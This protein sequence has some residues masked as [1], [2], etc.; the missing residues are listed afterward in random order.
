MSDLKP[1]PFTGADGK[2]H[3]LPDMRALSTRELQAADRGDI[4]ALEAALLR[5]GAEQ[6]DVDALFDLPLHEMGDVITAWISGDDEGK[7]SKPSPSSK[8][9]ATR[10]KRTSPSAAS[11][12]RRR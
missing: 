10:S 7:P 11:G 2:S 9:T 3:K 6:A 8:N 4:D 1:F 5:R 12:T